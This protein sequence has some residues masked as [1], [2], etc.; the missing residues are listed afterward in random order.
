MGGKKSSLDFSA[1]VGAISKAHEQCVA[2]AGRTINVSLTLRN[3]VIG[4]H[5]AEFEL[6]GADRAVYGEHPVSYTHLTLPTN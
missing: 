2:Q 6:N 4:R 1:L 3:W 5:I